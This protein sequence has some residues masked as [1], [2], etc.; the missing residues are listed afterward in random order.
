MKKG[1]L[2]I[3]CGVPGSGKST[4]AEEY[5]KNHPGT[6]VIS[7]DGIREEVFGDAAL[8]YTEEIAKEQ[9][10]K[11]HITPDPEN[12]D[13]EMRRVC[14]TYIFGIME[15]RVKKCLQDGMDVIYDATSLTAKSRVMTLKKF[16]GNY[17]KASAFYLDTPKD[18]A[19]KRNA[20]RERKVPEDVIL[21]MLERYEYPTKKEGFVRIHR[22]INY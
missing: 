7:S 20:A 17:N 10:Q 5:K 4:F 15:D 21:S 9:F 19:L 12:M 16:R 8:Q 18:V 14:N 11:Q 1:N 6:E 22:V 2:I 13:T 3:L